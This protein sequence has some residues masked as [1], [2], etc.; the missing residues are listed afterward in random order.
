MPSY[1][2][3]C[4]NCKRTLTRLHKMAEGPGQCPHCSGILERI[5]SGFG[6]AVIF[7]GQ[8]F[9]CNDY[10]D[11]VAKEDNRLIEQCEKKFGK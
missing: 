7:K 9:H 3:A 10:G 1:D 2:Y 6:G 8:G 4:L 5:W 11:P